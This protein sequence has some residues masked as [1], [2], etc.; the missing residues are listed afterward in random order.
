MLPQSNLKLLQ[1]GAGPVQPGYQLRQAAAGRHVGLSPDQWLQRI[2]QNEP[3][4]TQIPASR[5][6]GGG[7]LQVGPITG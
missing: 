4:L 5:Q 1:F 7:G 3:G 2:D 6:Q